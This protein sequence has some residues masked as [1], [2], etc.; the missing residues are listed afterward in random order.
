MNNFLVIGSNIS[1]E[2]ETPHLTLVFLIGHLFVFQ[3][4]QSGT[5]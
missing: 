3:G 4:A 1:C 5:L 2:P